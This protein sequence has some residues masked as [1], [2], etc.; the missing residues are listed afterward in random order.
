MPTYEYECTSCG[1]HFTRSQKMTDK[2]VQ[3]CPECSG[4]VRRLITGGAGVIFKGSGFYATDYK[5]TTQNPDSCCGLTNPCSDP[6]RCCG[7]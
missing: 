6:K 7:K 5:K 3:V 4:Q 2:P 1:H